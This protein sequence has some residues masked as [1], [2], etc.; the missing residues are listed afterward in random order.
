MLFPQNKK[1]H[2]NDFEFYL[3]ELGTSKKLGIYILYLLS[4]NTLLTPSNFLTHMLMKVTDILSRASE[5]ASYLSK[6]MSQWLN[7]R[8]RP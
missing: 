1:L 6:Q 4:P 8:Y 3:S 5:N 7:Y 2:N